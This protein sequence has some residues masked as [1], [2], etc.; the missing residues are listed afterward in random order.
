[1]TDSVPKAYSKWMQKQGRTQTKRSGF[2]AAPKW[3]VRRVVRHYYKERIKDILR[4]VFKI[5]MGSKK[6][7]GSYQ[8]A[9]TYAI[10]ELSAESLARVVKMAEKL[11]RTDVPPTVK[12]E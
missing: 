12:D 5:P 2:F 1:M 9:V 4:N 6:M 8:A 11:N 7:I 10:E 3:T